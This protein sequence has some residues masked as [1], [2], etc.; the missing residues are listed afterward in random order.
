MILWLAMASLLLGGAAGCWAYAIPDTDRPMLERGPGPFGQG[1]YGGQDNCDRDNLGSGPCPG[2]PAGGKG[3]AKLILPPEDAALSSGWMR[4]SQHN[5][6][7]L[8]DGPTVCRG[9]NLYGQSEPPPG[10]F[11]WISV[12]NG[13]SC[14]VLESGQ[15]ICWG[16]NNAGQAR[17]RSSGPGR[18]SAQSPRKL[19]SVFRFF[20]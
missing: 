16:N 4:A 2:G 19:G 18:S 13:H 11:R 15:A 3:E 10:D 20:A 17:G 7:R 14:G 6:G 9:D 12:G 5:C 1:K 8:S